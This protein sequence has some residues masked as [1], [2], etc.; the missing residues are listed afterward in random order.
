[1]KCKFLLK[2]IFCF[3]KLVTTFSIIMYNFLIGQNVVTD[4]VRDGKGNIFS[5][6]YYSAFSKKLELLKLETYHSN[7][8]ISTL[9]SYSGGLKNGVYKEFYSNGN[10][11]ID[12]Q[13]SNGN[14]SGLWKEY[15]RKGG[16]MRMYHLNE[17]GKNGSVN[18]WYKNGEKKIHGGYFQ[19]QK[20]G[21]W[22]K[23]Y[24]NGVKESFITYNEGKQEGV[25]SYF[26][27]NGNKKSEGAVSYRGQ[28]EQR[29]WDIHG[30]TQN[31]IKG[32]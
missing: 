22:T 23:W 8:H 18:E 13:Y 3:S 7:G 20:H 12:G 26:Y 27:D 2:R 10:I 21:L 25:F 29:C 17:D 6:E 24:S 30:N 16:T 28:K 4:I 31:C 19:G 1:M 32:K 9:E 11:K 14:K 5:I 15:F